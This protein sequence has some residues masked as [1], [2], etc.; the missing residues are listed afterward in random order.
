[1]LKE[2]MA[3]ANTLSWNPANACSLPKWHFFEIVCWYK[4]YIDQKNKNNTNFF[5]FYALFYIF[6][7]VIWR[8]DI[9]TLPAEISPA[10]SR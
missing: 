6:L 4:I 10:T 5:I 3:K 2:F 9:E 7:D 8:R 1:M